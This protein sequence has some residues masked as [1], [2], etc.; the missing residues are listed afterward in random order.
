MKRIFSVLLAFFS[1]F[2]AISAQA[3]KSDALQSPAG[4]VASFSPTRGNADFM[5]GNFSFN[6]SAP[7]TCTYQITSSVGWVTVTNGNMQ[8]GN[9]TIA[10]TVGFNSVFAARAGVI[11]VG[12]RTFSIIQGGKGVGFR[13]APLDFN[14]DGNT[15]YT[16]IQN[17]NGGMA[18]WMYQY[19]VAPGGR[20]SGTSFGL[21]AD[22]VP[23]PNDFDGDQKTDV[24]VWRGGSV[25]NEQAYFYVLQSASNTVKVERWGLFGDNPKITQDF[26]GDFKADFSVTRNQNGALVWYI[27]LSATN[28][29][30]VQQF[31]T[32]NDFPVRGDYDGDYHA[33]VAFY[34]PNT[35]LPANTYFVFRSSN[36]AITTENFGLSQTDRL[37]PGDYDGDSKTDYAVWR[38]T[39][40]DWYWKSS[41]NGS[42]T[43]YSWGT[44]GDLPVPGDYNGDFKT[45]Y[46]VWRP[47][48]N[49]GTFWIKNTDGSSNFPSNLNWGNSTMKIPANSMQVP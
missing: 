23:L 18:W 26:D 14:G 29:L 2:A 24:A 5:G 8:T 48:T 15:D 13:K 32:A 4:C 1:F 38:T 42:I 36:N 7:I 43:V 31:G 28:S 47:G 16:A 33:D 3:Q 41:E 25:P 40:G 10:Y 35:G 22:D 49:Q 12:D 20:T 6:V 39:T 37:V 9:S 11:I 19:H 30:Y 44:T 34:R 46:A 17:V 21:F 45:D 27:L